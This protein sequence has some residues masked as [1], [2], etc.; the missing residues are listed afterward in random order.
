MSGLRD[1]RFAFSLWFPLTATSFIGTLAWLW[2]ALAF[3]TAPSNLGAAGGFALMGIS[4]FLGIFLICPVVF[5]LSIWQRPKAGAYGVIR[6][7]PVI[8]VYAALLLGYPFLS[9]L[10]EDEKIQ[11]QLL[12]NNK[13]P[14]AHARIEFNSRQISEGVFSFPSA[15]AHGTTES[16]ID[17]TFEVSA[18]STHD[19]DCEIK[20]DG[21]ADLR[22]EVRRG[23][24]NLG[25]WRQTSVNWQFP[26]GGVWA[27]QGGAVTFDVPESDSM[28][29]IVYLL[30]MNAEIPSYPPMRI[31]H[32]NPITWTFEPSQIALHDASGRRE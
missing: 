6:T 28:Q 23:W 17:G 15:G 26:P 2:A 4:I 3:L 22:V 12:D 20:K 7:L 25:R 32:G 31:F 19:L 29:L 21:F 9:H 1:K 5:G 18:P 27:G 14:V 11:I 24:K 8:C 13:K 30:K 16:R 10:I